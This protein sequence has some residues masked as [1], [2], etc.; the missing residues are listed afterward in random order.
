MKVNKIR[1]TLRNKNSKRLSNQR[2]IGL[3]AILG[4]LNF[5]FISLYQMGIVKNIP[6]PPGK[7]FDSDKA[8]GSLHAYATG[9]PDGPLAIV[10]YGV[11]L[12][13]ATFKGDSMSGRPRWADRVLL[14]LSLIN[15]S[16]AASYMKN[17]IEKQER[18]CPYCIAGA[19]INGL[20]LAFSIKQM[21]NEGN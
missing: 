13:L 1:T 18:A 12:I 7:F 20:I 16:S 4:L 8:N 15:G 2:N 10:A 5:S 6:D 9:T 21:A 11:T 19:I 3:L 17:M 14:F